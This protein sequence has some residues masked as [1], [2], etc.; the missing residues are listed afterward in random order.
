[1]LINIRWEF[2]DKVWDSD[3]GLPCLDKGKDPKRDEDLAGF[4]SNVIEDRNKP[5][6]S[7]EAAMSYC[8]FLSWLLQKVLQTLNFSL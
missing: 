8:H 6:S 5:K 7:W 3:Y 2:L 4:V 1:M